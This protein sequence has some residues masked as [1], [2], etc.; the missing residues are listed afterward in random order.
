MLQYRLLMNR[1]RADTWKRQVNYYRPILQDYHA[2]T[3]QLTDK[4]SEQEQLQ[5]NRSVLSPLQIVRRRQLAEQIAALTEEI[6]ELRSRQAMILRNLDCKNNG[7]AQR[8]G[9]YLD[10]PEEMQE[11]LAAQRESL[12]QQ[13]SATT[14]QYL[15]IENMIQPE[16]VDAVHQHRIALR[17]IIAIE[18][19]RTLYR[20][21]RVD[22]TATSLAEK[23]VDTEIENVYSTPKQQ[24]ISQSHNEK[25]R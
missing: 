14:K 8:F 22:D 6:E 20:E 11:K 17:P 1:K 15:E 4:K 19:E 13:L 7:E 21:S 2:V 3:Q 5:T 24:N 10:K 25:F 18:R 9:S 12:A 23:I 16:D